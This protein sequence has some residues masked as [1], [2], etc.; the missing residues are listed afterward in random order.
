MLTRLAGGGREDAQ[1]IQIERIKRVL[2]GYVTRT[3]L[4]LD[5]AR[6][7][8][9]ALKLITEPV[10]LAEVAA[11]ISE[12][13]AAKAESQQTHIE[14]RV[15]EAIVGYWDRAAIET[16][17]ANLVSN[18]LKYGE[19]APVTITGSIDGSGNAVIRVSDTGP[20]IPDSQRSLIFDK[21]NRASDRPVVGYGL[22]LWI[23]NQLA[24]L[25][26]GSVALEPSSAGATFV[27]TL[28]LGVLPPA[29]SPT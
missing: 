18:A 20:G 19:G 21:F 17:L 28:P 6:L 5:A 9:G 14:S 22:G 27:V 13:Y 8:G 16:I 7:T 15:T 12:L 29:R 23:A 3:S 1:R 11:A 25:H 2:D 24:I 10:A 26:D 4:L